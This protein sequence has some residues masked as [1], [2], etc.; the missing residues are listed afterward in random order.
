M[1]CHLYY[2][3]V[4]FTEEYEGEGEKGLAPKVRTGGR[5]EEALKVI[6]GRRRGEGL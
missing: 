5:R 1:R 2:A 4:L 6:V 3:R